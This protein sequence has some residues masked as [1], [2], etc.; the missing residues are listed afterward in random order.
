[1]SLQERKASVLCV[2]NGWSFK[3]TFGFL[4]YFGVSPVSYLQKKNILF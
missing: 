1:M 3:T 4:I 2:K